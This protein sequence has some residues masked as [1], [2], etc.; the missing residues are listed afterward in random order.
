MKP[1]AWGGS[2]CPHRFNYVTGIT[3]TIEESR[4][5]KRCDRIEKRI[6]D[7]EDSLTYLDRLETSI[8]R[9]ERMVENMLPKGY[10][11]GIPKEDIKI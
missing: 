9:L 6:G 5:E 2:S 11:K 8:K 4:L 1:T 10:I 7:I 3:K